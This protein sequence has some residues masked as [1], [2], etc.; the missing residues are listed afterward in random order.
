[1]SRVLIVT[2]S[3]AAVTVVEGNTDGE[4]TQSY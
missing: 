4:P 1:M 2:L 3:Q